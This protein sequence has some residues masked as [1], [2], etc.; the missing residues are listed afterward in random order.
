MERTNRPVGTLDRPPGNDL[1]TNYEKHDVGEAWLRDRL[2]PRFDVEERGIDKRDDDGGGGIIYDDKMDFAVA[3]DGEEIAFVDVKTKSGP[4]YFGRFNARHYDHYCEH[5]VDRDEPCFVVMA[6]VDRSSGDVEDAF[7]FEIP[8]TD[9]M[10]DQAVLRSDESTTLDAFPDGNEA[11]CVRHDF[12]RRMSYLD[13][14][15]RAS[16]ARDGD[17]PS[18]PSWWDVADGGN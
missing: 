18:P 17:V 16:S 7:V 14:R 13:D 15:L 10:A 2:E 11:V 9:D 8:A 4:R 6:Q 3:D 12:R 1:Q 5:A